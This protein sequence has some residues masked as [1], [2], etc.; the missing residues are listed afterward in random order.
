MGLPLGY[1]IYL[2]HGLGSTT[3]VTSKHNGERLAKTEGGNSRD[4]ESHKEVTCSWER[5]CFS[6]STSSSY[7]LS[8]VSKASSSTSWPHTSCN[9]TITD[10]QQ[11]NHRPTTTQS[12]TYNNTITDL[13]QHNTHHRLTTTQSQTYNNTI[14]DLQ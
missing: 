9:N 5:F 2:I 3:V 11:H 4:S 12:Q 8:R 1:R 6:L 7:D 13:Q 14:T 10:L